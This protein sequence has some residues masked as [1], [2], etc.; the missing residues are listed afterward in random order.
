MSSS[1]VFNKTPFFQPENILQT[2]EKKEQGWQQEKFHDGPPSNYQAKPIY[3]DTLSEIPELKSQESNPDPQ[4]QQKKQTEE[5]PSP[6]PPKPEK[7]K[8]AKPG[9]KP[10]E[11]QQ[12]P[13][14]HQTPAEQVNYNQLI[15][16]ARQQGIQEGLAQAALDF[17]TSTSA[18]LNITE[19]LNHTR[20]TILQNSIGEMQDLVLTIAEKII[21]HSITAQ[22]DT[23]VTTVEDAIRQAVKSDE[24]YICIHQDDYDVL[25][26][27]I[28]E[29]LTKISGLENIFIKID[30]NI[31]P[32]GCKVESDNCTV[33][34]T[35][36]SQLQILSDEIKSRR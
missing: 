29:I 34:A 7:I 31:D 24:F 19:Q 20:E 10:V 12:Q 26:A 17:Q 28:P 23:I 30:N 6:V 5:Q 27:K 35:I 13:P 32:G 21:R 1:K 3:E 15:E 25:N 14:A 36:A 18:L 4:K 16:E 11:T 2:T 8:K 22:D 33:D 9:P